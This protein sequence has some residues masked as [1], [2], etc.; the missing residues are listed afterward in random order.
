[1]IRFCTPRP[2]VVALVAV[3]LLAVPIAVEAKERAYSARG[4]AQFVSPTDFVGQ[5]NATHLGQY[6]EIGSVQFSPTAYPNV[7]QVD[8]LITY[9]AADG[10][11]LD[12]TVT[13]Y[14]DTMTG[15]ITA[16]IAYDGGTGR[17]TYATGSSALVGQIQ[18]DGTITVAVRGTIDF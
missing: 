15:A 2:V 3:G 5:G 4:T 1:M 17:F 18:L 9:T 12:A 8:G 10:D 14:L 13:G 7:L 16:T 11:E 6:K